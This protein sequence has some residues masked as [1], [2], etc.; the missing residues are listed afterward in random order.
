MNLEFWR[1]RASLFALNQEETR[2]SS[3]LIFAEVAKS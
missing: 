2:K 3:W 1:L